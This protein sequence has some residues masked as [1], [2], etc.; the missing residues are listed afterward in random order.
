MVNFS[1]LKNIYNY[2]INQLLADDGLTIRCSLRYGVSKKIICPNCIFDPAT[3]KS[4]N[5]YKPSGPIAFTL[6]RTCP[7]CHGIGYYGSNNLEEN[8]YL[9]VLWDSKSWI[10]F[11]TNVQST[12]SMIQTISGS[13]LLPKI[14]SANNLI[15][16]NESYELAGKPLYVGLGDTSYI[17]CNWKK[18]NAI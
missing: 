17:I 10:N 13:E 8:I 18:I 7:Y 2:Q 3:N 1:Q 11:P 12:D 15:I 6:G 4:S 5:R 16:K 9:A 14:E